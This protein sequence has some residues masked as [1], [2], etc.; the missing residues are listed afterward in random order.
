[1]LPSWKDYRVEYNL[2]LLFVAWTVLAGKNL[3][4]SLCTDN[5][6]EWIE[7]TVKNVSQLSK[8]VLHVIMSMQPPLIRD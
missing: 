4:N 3:V 1:M 7:I 5:S 6:S 8:I 2:A